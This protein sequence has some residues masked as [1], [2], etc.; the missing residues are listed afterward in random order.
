MQTGATTAHS[1]RG[2]IASLVRPATTVSR[3]ATV[4]DVAQAMVRHGVDAV[5][6]IGPNGPDRLVTE[7]DVVAL[8]AAGCDPGS[9]PV[10]QVT[11]RLVVPV[12]AAIDAVAALMLDTDRSHLL[13]RDVDRR[14]RGIVSLRDVAAAFLR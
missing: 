9:T 1:T 3:E 11:D 7:Q 13:V 10:P 4:L 6:M 2:T 5:L 8:L 14:I 12:T